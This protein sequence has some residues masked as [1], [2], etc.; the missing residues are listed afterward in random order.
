MAPEEQRGQEA[1]PAKGRPAARLQAVI[2]QPVRLFFAM[3]AVIVVLILASENWPLV[4]FSLLGV[5]F[6]IPGTIVYLIFLILGMIIFWILNVRY[7]AAQTSAAER[8]D[9][10]QSRE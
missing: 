3:L 2:Q 6:D 1:A 10:S 9:A 4:R 8:S 5:R 7:A